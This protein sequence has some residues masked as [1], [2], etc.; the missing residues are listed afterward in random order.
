MTLPFYD[1]VRNFFLI[2]DKIPEERVDLSVFNPICLPTYDASFEDK[3][4]H[5]YGEHSLNY[6]VSLI[7]LP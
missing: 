5:V 7:L 1:W 2:S 4:G 3:T 6:K